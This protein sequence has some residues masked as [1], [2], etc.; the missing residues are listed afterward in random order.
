MGHKSDSCDAL[1]D[2]WQAVEAT[3]KSLHATINELHAEV[4]RLRERCKTEGESCTDMV[5]MLAEQEREIERLK[6]EVNAVIRASTEGT[7]FSNP[8]R[9]VAVGVVGNMRDA[10]DRD[11]KEVERL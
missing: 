10:M 9:S 6:C 2:D 8:I 1:C 7:T 5:D 11:E 3:N 4:A